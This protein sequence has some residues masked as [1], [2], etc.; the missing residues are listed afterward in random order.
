MGHAS[1][2]QFIEIQTPKKLPFNNMDLVWRKDVWHGSAHIIEVEC[3][4]IPHAQVLKFL[5]NEQ[6]HEDSL[7]EWNIYKQVST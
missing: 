1:K 2:S 3:A 4:Y 7:M 5:N 6:N